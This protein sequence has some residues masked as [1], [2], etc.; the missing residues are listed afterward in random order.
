MYSSYT[1]CESISV[2]LKGISPNYTH[3][4]LFYQLH[5]HDFWIF[6]I[7]LYDFEIL[8]CFDCFDSEF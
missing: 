8:S 7:E 4:L 1:P 3:D 2:R 6:I 5:S